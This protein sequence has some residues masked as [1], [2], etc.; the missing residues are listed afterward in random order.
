MSVQGVSMSGSSLKDNRLRDY[1]TRFAFGGAITVIAGLV[2]DHYGAAA[3]GSLLAFPASIT[4]LADHEKLKKRRVGK[5]G[6][7]RGR[8]AAAID[9]EG[10]AMAC[11][12][13]AVFAFVAWRMLPDH[14]LALTLGTASAAWLVVSVTCWELRRRF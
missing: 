3:A 14:G 11:V 12:G 10:A 5:D 8:E 7:M 4:L 13:L 2:G 6:T 1:A 9:A